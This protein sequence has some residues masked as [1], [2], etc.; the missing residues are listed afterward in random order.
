[1]GLAQEPSSLS[2]TY[3]DWTLQCSLSNS[4]SDA[5]G[6]VRLCQVSQELR[7]AGS[8]DRIV[9][10]IVNSNPF[11]MTIVTPLGLLLPEGVELSVGLHQLP[12]GA[13]RTC[14]SNVGCVAENEFDAEGLAEIRSSETLSVLMTAESGQKLQVDLSLEGFSDAVMRLE[15]IQ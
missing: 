4:S 3:G 11:R 5:E 9:T 7:K 2:E 12:K 8:G 14:L 10:V 13:F 1:M 6:A 15:S